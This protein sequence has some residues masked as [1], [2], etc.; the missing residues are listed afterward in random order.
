M[1]ENWR[2]TLRGL[3]VFRNE[4]PTFD[5]GSAPSN[6]LDLF[7]EWMSRAI[8]Q[9][10]EQPHAMTLA[11]AGP[12]ART[13]ILKNVDA[14]GFWFASS[15]ESPKGRELDAQPRA[16][17]LFYWR[18]LGRQ[19]RI[20]GA[21]GRGSAEESAAD[22]RERGLHARA[23]VLAGHQS[24]P[25]ERDGAEAVADAEARAKS[26]EISPA[27][28]AYFVAAESVEFWQA[29][30]TRE[31]VRLLYTRGVGGWRTDILVP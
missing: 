7:D 16:A 14:R 24:E 5:T 27:W 13:V 1:N 21:V 3:P 18:E 10:V 28:T 29:S 11:T 20:V 12:A 19:V 15:S 17:L 25:V 23:G 30:T 2:A 31:H 22:F 8:E 26:G 4:L 6:P 9:G